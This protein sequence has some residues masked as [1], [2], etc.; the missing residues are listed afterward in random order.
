MAPARDRHKPVASAH[1]EVKILDVHCRIA[2]IS[3]RE[4]AK[5]SGVPERTL[6]DW[7]Y[8]ADPHV[9]LLKAALGVFGLKLKV[10]GDDRSEGDLR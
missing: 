2:S 1:D 6:A 8:G 10:S 5:R 7:W 4:L 3:R 9:S